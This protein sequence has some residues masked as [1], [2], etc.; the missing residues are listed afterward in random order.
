MRLSTFKEGF[1]V[2]LTHIM[3]VNPVELVD[4]KDCGVLSYAVHAK[5]LHQLVHAENFLLA[6]RCPAQKCQEVVDSLGQ[7]T[8]LT[9]LVNTGCTMTLAHLGVI[10]AQNQGDMAKGGFFEAKCIINQALARSVG[11][12]L[13]SADYMGDVHQGIVNN[14]SV[15]IGGNAVRFNNNEIADV[16]GIKNNV[17]T[18][19]VAH[20]NLLVSRHTEADSRLTA[21]G[22]EFGNLLLR[23][24]TALAHVARHFA[25]LNQGLAFLLQLLVGAV[26]I[27]GLTLCQQLV[28][29]FFVQVQALHLMV[30]AIGAAY[31]NALIPIHSQ[32]F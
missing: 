27:V 3:L 32:P 30:R 17:A 28:S 11:K 10:L 15:I 21:F 9:V 19:H 4:I 25:F 22:L 8:Q 6:V 29:I 5:F 2:Q 16:V 31:V 18:H 14:N 1:S 7:I 23:Q 12:M 20:Q 13:L 24:M 26:A